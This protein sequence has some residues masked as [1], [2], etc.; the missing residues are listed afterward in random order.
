[1][2]NCAATPLDIVHINE[3]CLAYRRMT[4]AES[5]LVSLHFFTRV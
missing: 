3:A 2:A 1:M 4:P 5:T